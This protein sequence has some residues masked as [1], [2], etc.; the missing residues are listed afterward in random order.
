MSEEYSNAGEENNV[1]LEM[2]EGRAIKKNMANIKIRYRIINE[3]RR[4]WVERAGK[5]GWHEILT[6]IETGET[7]DSLTRGSRLLNQ[8]KLGM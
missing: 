8:G 6:K 5:S 2:R 4:G 1:G 3:A 7:N